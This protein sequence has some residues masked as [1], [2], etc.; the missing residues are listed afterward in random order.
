MTAA[1][2]AYG[3]AVLAR[4]NED[5]ADAT[6]GWGRRLLQRIFGV[7]E[8]EQDVPEAIA[9]LTAAPD[10]P[11]LQAVLRVQIGKLLRADPQLAAEVQAMLTQAQAVTGPATV[12]VSGE[13]AVA[14]GRDITGPV[15]TGDNSPISGP[16]TSEV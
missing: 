2:S 15:S 10:D 12:T 6:V 1:I 14:A 3:G 5:A 4:A 13:R 16:P 11:D 9:E 8:K 7:R